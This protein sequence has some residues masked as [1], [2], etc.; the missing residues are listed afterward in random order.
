MSGFRL[1]AFII[2]SIALFTIVISTTITSA[3]SEQGFTVTSVSLSNILR[4]GQSTSQTQWLVT[5]VL[6]GGGQNLIGSLNNST[7]NY[8]G[9]KSVYPIQISGST[10]PE[11]AYYQVYN[12]NP[13]PIYAFTDLAEN[14]TLGLTFGLI[15]S[16]SNAPSCPSTY[17]SGT[18]V[19]Q[20][21]VN[22]ENLATGHVPTISR[23]CIYEQAIGYESPISATP[24][25]QS[26]STLQLSA[27]GRQ[28]TLNI[29]YSQ[30]SATS[31]DGLVQANWV[32]SLV[33][34][35][36]APGGNL[37]VA[38]S[39]PQQNS[40]NVQSK[41]TYNSYIQTLST[42]QAVYSGSST[43]YGLQSLPQSCGGLGQNAN[44]TSQTPMLVATCLMNDVI[45]PA[46]AV[47]NQDAQSLLSS[48]V[49][50]GN[51]QTQFITNNGQSS[52]L[53]TLNNNFVNS[54]EVTLRISGSFIGVVIPEGTPKIVSATS[55]PFNSGNNGTIV[56]NVE[57]VGTATG[58]F[59]TSLSNCSGIQ[60]ITSPKY[61]VQPGQSQV[62]NIPISTSTTKQIINEQCTVTVTDYNG[63][64]SS[65]IRVNIQSKPANQCT[66]NTQSVQGDYICSCVNVNGIYQTGTGSA[67]T[68]CLYGVIQ[69]NGNYKCALAPPTIPSNNV[70]SGSPINGSSL[71]SFI[72]SPI[73]Q[74]VL[75]PVATI[76][77]NHFVCP[78]IPYASTIVSIANIFGANIPFCT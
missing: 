13:T 68:Y 37:Y 1:R 20:R 21:D 15:T 36:S 67:C 3:Q 31:T 24:N 46:F 5:I 22:I 18:Y 77:I 43:P 25:I 69:D 44:L 6:N 78:A 16:Y 45:S 76:A 17:S 23:V 26:S 32:G 38:I 48:T 60:T 4:P 74:Q 51:S 41:S 14:G 61:S 59:Y 2:L 58:S 35:N 33:T 57:N 30:Q 39:N 27:N 66:P 70:N 71:N 29:N 75:I 53:V 8:Q 19:G 52:F 42:T 62:I 72:N 34:G 47:N 65:D 28:Q 56:V 40:W 64:G 11:K 54:Q 49:Q 50:I 55:S 9:F 73:T 63:G 10:N 7:I 12:T